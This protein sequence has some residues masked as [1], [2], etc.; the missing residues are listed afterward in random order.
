[1]LT[2]QVQ[3]EAGTNDELWE[4]RLDGTHVRRVSSGVSSAVL[5]PPGTWTHDSRYFLFSET[6]QSNFWL[7][8][9]R[10]PSHGLGFES[11]VQLNTGLLNVTDMVAD[12]DRDR[13]LAIEA[14]D[15]MEIFRYNLKSG[16][17]TPFLRGVSADGL[18]FSRSGDWVAYITYPDRRLVCGRVD[19]SA[20]RQLT[21]G[22]QAALLPAWSPDGKRIAYMARVGSGSWKVNLISADGGQPEELTPGPEDQANPTW[23]PDGLSLIYAGA[24]WVKG[25]AP[26]S[27]PIHLVDLRSRKVDV[28]PQ[29]VGL[30]SPRWSPD[31][32]YLVAET[33]D[34]Q[35]LMLFDFS[36]KTWSLLMSMP[37][38][39]I[40][41]TSWSHDSR[42]VYF[43][44]YLYERGAIYRVDVLHRA[45]ERV[46]DQP[47][48]AVTLG[49]WFTLAPDDSP[50]MLKDT[51]VHE[52]FALDLRL[53]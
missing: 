33:M 21:S 23:S 17:A 44:R 34:S 36:A 29:S 22:S 30:W 9:L 20:R 27:T 12:A 11:R 50:I 19:G 38:E 4:A 2:F 39:N 10:Q 43:N 37:G 25:F 16:A 24:P 40:G 5:H 28:L 42:W 14:L 32:K 35:R 41:Y 3:R 8:G 53:P 51:S 47:A 45:V 13:I 15:R 18:A 48:M 1:L 52:V 26:N 46:L 49:Q 31:G 7:W 6:G